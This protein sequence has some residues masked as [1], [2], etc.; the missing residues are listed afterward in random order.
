MWLMPPRPALLERAGFPLAPV[1]LGLVLGPIVERNFMQSVIKTNWDLTQFLTRPISATLMI[2]TLLV[3]AYPLLRGVF[4]GGVARAL[5]VRLDA[6][7]DR[8]HIR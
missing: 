7:H 6:D 3:L 4:R 8:Q 2:L 5:T 1:V